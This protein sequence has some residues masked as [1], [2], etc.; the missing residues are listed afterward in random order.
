MKKKPKKLCFNIPIRNATAL[1]VEYVLFADSRQVAQIPLPDWDTLKTEMEAL[2]STHN[3]MSA[4]FVQLQTENDTFVGRVKFDF[5]R[6]QALMTDSATAFD[7][8][9]SALS[10]QAQSAQ[11]TDLQQFGRE[12]ALVP[13][14]VNE[15]TLRT[16]NASQLQQAYQYDKSLVLRSGKEQNFDFFA[17]YNPILKQPQVTLTEKDLGGTLR[18]DGTTGFRFTLLPNTFIS[19]QFC[20]ILAPPLVCCAQKVTTEQPTKLPDAKTPPQTPQKTLPAPKVKQDKTQ[21]QKQ[22]PK[23]KNKS[24]W[25]LFGLLLGVLLILW[26]IW[27]WTHGRD[28]ESSF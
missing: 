25:W 27:W 28:A 11:A 22:E 24:V 20:Y 9:A 1:P 15:I 13:I 5:T 10:I 16:N 12:V 19:L 7:N 4:E 6:L 2:E 17:K 26:G 14:L 8:L 3:D 23:Q 21:P 18:F